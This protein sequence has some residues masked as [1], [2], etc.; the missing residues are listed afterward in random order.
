MPAFSEYDRNGDGKTL[1]MEFNEARSKR[2]SER[3]QQGYRMKN[4]GNVPL[5]SDI[6]TNRGGGG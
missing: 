5:F 4:P 6:D 2:I 3:A 1:E